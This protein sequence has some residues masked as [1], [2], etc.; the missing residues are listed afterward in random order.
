MPKKREGKYEIDMD[1][2]GKYRFALKSSNGRIV[3][4]S[5]GYTRLHGCIKGIEAVRRLANSRIEINYK[6][7]KKVAR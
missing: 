5:Q 1:K 2:R 6:S 3:V 4:P 7:F